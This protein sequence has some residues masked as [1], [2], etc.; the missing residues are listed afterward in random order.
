[1][2]KFLFPILL[3]IAIAL[4]LFIK[5]R[6]P[7]NIEN[8]KAPEFS[9]ELIDGTP[10]NL[11]DLRGQYVV[12]DFWGSWCAPCRKE[13][14][15]LVQLYKSFYGQKFKDADGFDVVTIALEKNDK[16]WKKASQ[17][18]GFIWKNQIVKQSRFVLTDPLAIKYQVSS[19]PTKLL[20][21]PKGQIVSTNWS[22]QQ[23]RDY[24]S[25]RLR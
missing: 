4:F 3:V 20:I 5:S 17:K 22:Y 21:D 12:L 10:F 25:A 13:N 19:V 1:M 15:Q 14:P 2:K 6:S 23:I 16:R 18:D 24:L 9:A 7:N 11:T 8:E